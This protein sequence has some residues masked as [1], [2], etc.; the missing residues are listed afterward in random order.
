M[1][2][3]SLKVTGSG[4]PGIENVG[5]FEL[6]GGTISTEANGGIGFVRGVDLQRSKPR[7]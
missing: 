6:S 4:K 5:S 2:G 7:N 3:G 1:T